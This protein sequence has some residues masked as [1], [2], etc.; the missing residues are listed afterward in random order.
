MIAK[1]KRVEDHI[2][3][4]RETFD[5]LR[6]NRILLN[7]EKCVFRVSGGKCLGFIVD[8]RG[9]EAKAT[10]VVAHTDS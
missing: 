3:H 6:T 8:E 1:S 9:I 5:T 10:K 2:E 7:P 4:L